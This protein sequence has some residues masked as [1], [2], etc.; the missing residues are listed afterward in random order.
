[1]HLGMWPA[2]QPASQGGRGLAAGS[3]SGGGW[4]YAILLLA[5]S[6]GALGIY[7]SAKIGQTSEA[8]AFLPV[9]CLYTLPVSVFSV[10]FLG[11]TLSAAG[12]VGVVIG[13]VGTVLIASA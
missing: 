13:A 4:G 3:S 12:W 8:S 11:E 6:C 1:M 10:A 2:N 5:Q 9:L 7:T